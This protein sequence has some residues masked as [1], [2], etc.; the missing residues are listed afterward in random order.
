M[1]NISILFV[2]VVFLQSCTTIKC[3]VKADL[4]SDDSKSI[5]IIQNDDPIN[6]KRTIANEVNKIGFNTENNNDSMNS[7]LTYN[8]IHYFDAF[9]YTLNIFSLIVVKNDTKEVLASAFSTGDSPSGANGIVSATFAK[10]NVKLKAIKPN[11]T[12]KKKN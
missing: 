9:H 5:S 1:K 11:D 10:L 8:Y 4:L 6:L 7:Y 3:A 2:M 12:I